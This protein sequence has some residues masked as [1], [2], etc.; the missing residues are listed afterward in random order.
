MRNA[1]LFFVAAIDR[2]IWAGNAF[3]RA[4]DRWEEKART[5]LWAKLLNIVFI[6]VSIAIMLAGL[7]IWAMADLSIYP[8]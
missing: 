7:A 6:V 2:V 5:C 3:D 4:V 1:L 8:H